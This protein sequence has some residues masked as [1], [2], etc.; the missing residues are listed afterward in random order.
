MD[1]DQAAVKGE[2]GTGYE[3][4]EKGP[5]ACHNCE[6]FNGTCGQKVMMAQSQLPKADDGRVQVDRDGCCEYVDR[7]GK[8]KSGGAFEVFRQAHQGRVAAGSKE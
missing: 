5:F 8:K 1:I 2:P 4:P 6:Y 3:G 7:T